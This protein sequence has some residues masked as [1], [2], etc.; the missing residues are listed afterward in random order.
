[1]FNQIHLDSSLLINN[2]RLIVVANSQLIIFQY[3]VILKIYNDCDC[4][5]ISNS[6]V[7][8]K[9]KSM[10]INNNM[11]DELRNLRITSWPKNK[12]LSYILY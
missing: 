11:Y 12:L 4:A 10:I 3:S 9:F 7:K 5:L 8:I 1:M 2:Y 6:L